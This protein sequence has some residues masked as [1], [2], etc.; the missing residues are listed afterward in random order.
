MKLVFGVLTYL[1]FVAAAVVAA[2][3]ALTELQSSPPPQAPV[4]AQGAEP[5]RKADALDDTKVDPNRVPVWIAPTPKYDYTPVAVGD[6]RHRAVIT[7]EARGALAKA[8]SGT[9]VRRERSDLA[10]DQ[11]APRVTN[12]RRDNDPF[13]RD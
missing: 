7:E 5:V 1:A 2:L 4:L 9:A 12:S 6:R 11:V 3:A 13:F 10:N 8:P